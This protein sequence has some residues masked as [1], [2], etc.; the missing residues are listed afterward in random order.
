[1]DCIFCN[2]IKGTI[3]A[4]KIME[5]KKSLAFLDGFPL[6]KGHTLV[7]PKNHYTKL[8][9][10]SNEDNVDLFETVRTLTDRIESLFSSSL[11]AVHNGK[12]SGQEV[13]HVHVHIIPRTV[14]DG[15]GP[16]HGMFRKRPQLTNDELD[17]IAEKI[18]E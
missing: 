6:T 12:E 14:A 10:M 4:R 3:F 8:Q 11:I 1:M 9:Q 7:I 18:R 13:P 15:A 16:V 5:T 17:Q 2:I